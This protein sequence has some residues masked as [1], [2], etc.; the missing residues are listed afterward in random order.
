MQPFFSKNSAR[1]KSIGLYIRTKL[2]AFP[3]RTFRG[4]NTKA[5]VIIASESKKEAAVI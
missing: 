4:A 2:I 1:K 5:F 3:I